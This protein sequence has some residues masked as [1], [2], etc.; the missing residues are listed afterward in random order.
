MLPHVDAQSQQPHRHLISHKEEVKEEDKE[1]KEERV[2]C[3]LF[4]HPSALLYSN[5]NPAACICCIIVYSTLSTLTP[6]GRVI[7]IHSTPNICVHFLRS[8]PPGNAHDW[9][10]QGLH[11]RFLHMPLNN[12]C[13]PLLNHHRLRLPFKTFQSSSPLILFFFPLFT[14]HL[15]HP[16]SSTPT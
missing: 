12:N 3:C 8:L 13:S 15:Q 2:K 7:F 6:P 4:K 1:D 10:L 14:L 5:S 9:P 16:P 11:G